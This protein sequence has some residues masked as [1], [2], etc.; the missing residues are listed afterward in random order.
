MVTQG[1]VALI[2]GKKVPALGTPQGR[3]IV[4]LVVMATTAGRIAINPADQGQL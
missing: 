2:A 4:I 1:I 3:N